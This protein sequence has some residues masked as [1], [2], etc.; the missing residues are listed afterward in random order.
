MRD[1]LPTILGMCT[2]VL[3]PLLPDLNSLIT[4]SIESALKAQSAGLKNTSVFYLF[5][6]FD[7]LSIMTSEPGPS[8]PS[9][10]AIAFY[11][12]RTMTGRNDRG[13]R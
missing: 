9:I 6:R 10:A 13:H 3:I 4:F 5:N 11:R 7:E 2:V 8:S 12:L 1:L